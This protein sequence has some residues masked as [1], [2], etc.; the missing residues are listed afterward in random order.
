MNIY[1]DESGSINNHSRHEK[2]FVIALIKVDDKK[3][4]EKAY[5]RFVSSNIERLK[6]LDK[7]K[8]DENGQII[9][10]SGKMFDGDSF[11]ELKGAQFDREMK[12]KFCEHF[13]KYGGFEV[14]YI[15]LDNSKLSNGLC[16]DIATAFNYPLK[17][18]IEYFIN[19]GYLSKEEIHLQL[20]ERNEKTNKKF[21]L[22]QYLSTE[23][24]AKGVLNNNID[25]TYFDSANNKFVQVADVFANLYYSNLM[26][27]K[28][29]DHIRKL[30]EK[31]I[32]K[33]VFKFPL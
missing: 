12:I 33:F 27:G 10:E 5:K 8:F 9:R 3:K 29:N 22:Q 6:I 1:I 15:K 23:L 11:K 19:K 13:S 25:V 28:Y 31:G 21:F 17:L 7:D 4:V 30:K 2:F 14:F 18:A 16:S 20:D 32:L 24:K 26:V